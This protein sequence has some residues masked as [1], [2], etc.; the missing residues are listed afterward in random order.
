VP[1]LSVAQSSDSEEPLVALV[2]GSTSGLGREVAFRL[3]A[4]GAHVIVHGRNE[5]RGAEVVAQIESDGRGSARFYRADLASLDEIR[6]FA[7]TI[8]ADYPHMDILVNNAGV[9]FV[10]GDRRLSSDGH[11]LT[12][13]VNYLA[14]FLLT[15]ELLPLLKDSA[16]SR[17]VNVSSGAAA[18]IDFDNVMLEA[19]YEGMRAY[20]QSKLAQVMFT[21]DL[22][23]ELDGVGVIVNSLHPAGFMDTNM[24]ISAWIEP[25]SSVHEGADAV[26]HLITGSDVG[27]GQFFNGLKVARAHPQAYS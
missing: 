6:A 12:F 10:N 24:V 5:E 27:H 8:R 7:A 14:G 1:T 15:Y 25:R 13:A 2:T 18:P 17:I 16:P 9:F 23:A 11:E 4:E 22:A 3:A 26:M 21:I 20:W 19:D